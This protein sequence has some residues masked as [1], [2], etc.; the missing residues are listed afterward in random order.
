MSVHGMHYG[1]GKMSKSKKKSAQAMK[2]HMGGKASSAK[3]HARS[4]MA[5][6]KEAGLSRN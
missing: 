6:M 3:G 2:S 4:V 1:G 5:V